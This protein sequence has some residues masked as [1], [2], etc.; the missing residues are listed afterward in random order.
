MLFACGLS[1]KATTIDF[2]TALPPGVLTNSLVP[3]GA[4]FT[5]TG[6]TVDKATNLVWS[7]NVRL[8]NRQE[9]P[10]DVGV[11]ICPPSPASCPTTEGGSINE[12]DNNGST[13][14]VLRFAFSTPVEIHSIGLSS[15][16]SGL[17][18][19]F[20]IFGSNT[21]QPTLSGLVAIA[22]GTNTSAGSVN[23][24]ILINQTFQYFFVTS[25]KR[26][27]NDDDSDFLVKNISYGPE[28]FTLGLVGAGL[29]GL[30]AWRR[31]RR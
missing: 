1:V 11:G 31:W 17:K 6:F 14:D 12:I 19:G 5:L 22:S 16:D 13:F 21:A 20:A 30:G 23:P 29:L 27:A 10:D 2:S 26:G 15:L 28:P 18:D 7:D 24:T 4:I 3:S 8:V 9:A 25:L